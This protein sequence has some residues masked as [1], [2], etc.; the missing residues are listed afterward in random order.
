[1]F[2]V[3]DISTNHHKDSLENPLKISPEIISRIPLE[4]SLWIPPE[5][6]LQEFL[7]KSFSPEILVSTHLQFQKIHHSLSNSCPWALSEIFFRN[8]STKIFQWFLHEFFQSWFEYAFRFLLFF[9]RNSFH[10]ACFS[11][12]FQDFLYTFVKDSWRKKSIHSWKYYTY[13]QFSR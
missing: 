5:V 1:M 12:F 11:F 10:S 7:K 6:F 8:C 9:C 4:I 2:Q 13:K 3:W